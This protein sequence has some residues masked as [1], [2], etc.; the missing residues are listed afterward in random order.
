MENKLYLCIDLKSFYASVEC[1]ERHL[2]PFKVNLVVA[3]PDRGRGAI[4]L[5][6]TPAIKKLGVRSRGRIY[7]IPS[8][9]D[10]I[11]APPRM[12]LYIKYSCKVQSIFLKYLSSDDIHSYSID[13]AFLDI[14]PYIKLYGLKP[15]DLALKI[16]DDIY[17]ETGLTATCGIGT[18]LF[19]AKVALDILAKHQRNNIAYLDEENFKKTIWYHRPITDVWMIGSGIAKRLEKYNIYDLHGICLIDPQILYKEFGVNAQILIDHAH[20]I[21]PVEIK[22]IKASKPRSHSI[23]NSQ[24]LFEDYTWEDAFLVL[25]EMVD[26][27]CLALSKKHLVTNHISLFIGYS[28]NIRKATKTSHKINN[29]SN[30]YSIIM[31]EFEKLFLESVDRLYPIR[32]IAIGLGNLKDERFESYDLFVDV[33]EIEKERKLKLAI[34]DIHSKYGKNALLKGMN[35]YDKATQRYRNKVIGGHKAK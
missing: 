23:S 32:Q 12:S 11:I 17:R 19:L 25:K 1:V 14:T 3:D 8:N 21:E 5:A 34:N 7:E 20:G 31:P 27:N 29:T 24:I 6:A 18:N 22:N 26:A 13:E 35:L 4:T 10:Y 9:I 33:D 28:K 16:L 30:A 15:M 2:D